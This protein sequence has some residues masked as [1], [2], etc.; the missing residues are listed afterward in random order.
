MKKTIFVALIVSLFLIGCTPKIYDSSTTPSN[1]PSVEANIQSIPVNKP[2]LGEPNGECCSDTIKDGIV[3]YGNQISSA[4]HTIDS[5]DD[6]RAVFS[7]LIPY[8]GFLEKD[9][10]NVNV[11]CNNGA[12]VNFNLMYEKTIPNVIIIPPEYEYKIVITYRKLLKYTS[13][14]ECVLLVNLKNGDTASKKFNIKLIG[15]QA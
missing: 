9:V 5:G 7:I 12:Q 2:S 11:Y 15:T 3:L 13:T 1:K 4:R 10:S 8:S 6:E 14:D